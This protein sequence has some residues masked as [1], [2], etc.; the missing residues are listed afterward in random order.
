MYLLKE[1]LDCLN[2]I[3]DEAINTRHNSIPVTVS[4]TL[5]GEPLELDYEHGKENVTY[6][7][8]ADQLMGCGCWCGAEVKLRRK[9]KANE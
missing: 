8:E 2:F 9:N 7:I 4:F 1:V 3:F 6:A 5:D